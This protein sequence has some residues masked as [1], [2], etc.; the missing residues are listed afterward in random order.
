MSFPTVTVFCVFQLGNLQSF[1]C[2]SPKKMSFKKMDPS[3][4]IGFYCRTVQDFEAASEEI[5]KVGAGVPK[6]R[7]GCGEG[8]QPRPAEQ[9]RFSVWH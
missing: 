6:S 1:H 5:T 2:P 7:T 9:T 4:T 3:C 8:N